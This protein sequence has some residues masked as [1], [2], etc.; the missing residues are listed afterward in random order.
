V[1]YSIFAPSLL[2]TNVTPSSR[3]RLWVP[4]L[5]ILQ[6]VN[7]VHNLSSQDE[8][9]WINNT[10]GVFVEK[11]IRRTIQQARSQWVEVP[12]PMICTSENII[13]MDVDPTEWDPELFIPCQVCR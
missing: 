10:A 6:D 11:Y 5:P 12:S 3:P 8:R 4:L 13:G 2:S 9:R 7:C 1:S